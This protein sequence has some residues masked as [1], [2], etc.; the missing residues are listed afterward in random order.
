MNLDSTFKW[1]LRKAESNWQ[2]HRVRFETAARVFADP[3][4][5]TEQDRIEQGE[6]RWQ[7]I[8]L[9]EGHLLLLVAHTFVDQDNGSEAVRLISA[10]KVDRKERMRY[11]NQIA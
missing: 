5:L 4:A 2:K 10:R 7:T 11:E 3:L 8:G 6:L 9:V 1:D